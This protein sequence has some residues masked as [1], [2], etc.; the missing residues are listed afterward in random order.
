MFPTF[1]KLKNILNIYRS[2]FN[3]YFHY[4]SRTIK[5]F[6]F[7]SNF[8]NYHSV[9][10]V[11]VKI[12]KREKVVEK[13]NYFIMKIFQ[14][15]QRCFKAMDIRAFSP[16]NGFHRFTLKNSLSCILAVLNILSAVA[17]GLF[18][19][20]TFLEYLNS[21]YSVLGVTICFAFYLMFLFKMENVFRLIENFE[22]QIKR[23][24]FISNEICS[25]FFVI[26]K[27]K[28]YQAWMIQHTK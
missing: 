24:K 3:D 22:N 7:R 19:A 6:R 8:Q 23:R 21:I 18:E 1:E 10:S 2:I 26:L 20:E 28:I 14:T 13:I 12:S 9:V 27:T 11:L 25:L 16:T 17:Y 15:I 5:H 4:K